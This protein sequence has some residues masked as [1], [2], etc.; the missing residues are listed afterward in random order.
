MLVRA[1]P[2]IITVPFTARL[3]EELDEIEEGKLEWTKA[4]A[5]FYEQFKKD[6]RAE[7]DSRSR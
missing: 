2:A 6:L 3:E 4:I 5:E 1:F 7:V